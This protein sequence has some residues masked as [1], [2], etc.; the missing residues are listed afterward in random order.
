LPIDRQA[1]AETLGFPG[2]TRNSIDATS[3]RDFI[4]EFCAAAAIC[5]GHL[6]RLAED[7]IL[8]MSQEFRFVTIADAFC[9]GSSMMPQKKNPDVME[10]VRG[11]VARVYAALTGMLTLTKGIPQAY[12]RD[13]QEDKIHLFSAHDTLK[14]SL[15]IAAAVIEHTEFNVDQ[16]KAATERGFLDATVLAE[17][18]VGRGVPF[19]QAHQ[20]V[21]QLVAQAEKSDRELKA[22]SLDEFQQVC[23]AIS[24][25]VYNYL[26]AENV[27]K[28]YQSAGNAGP[29]SVRKQ[30]RFWK[31]RLS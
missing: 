20:I 30:I 29:Q 17:Y 31:K 3:D 9:T 28:R 15:E 25:D 4:T 6:S 21:G 8:Y 18:L 13:L 19:R 1:V 10:L 2:I 26:T 24:D 14:A 27:V 7:L 22:L 5:S 12:N 23:D 11:K 16:L